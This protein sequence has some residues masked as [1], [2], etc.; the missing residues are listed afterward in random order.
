MT[1]ERGLNQTIAFYY[2][3][4]MDQKPGI[5]RIHGE[6]VGEKTV[7]SDLLKGETHAVSRKK[8]WWLP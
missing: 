5:L 1:A 2:M 4:M 8:L 6:E 3:D 7:T